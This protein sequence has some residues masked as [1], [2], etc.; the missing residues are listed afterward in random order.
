MGELPLAD[1]TG[2]GVPYW[3]ALS[4]PPLAGPAGEAE[5]ELEELPDSAGL[6]SEP[7]AGDDEPD[8]FEGEEPE[9]SDPD[10]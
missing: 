3:G 10:P 8:P 1:S 7:D 6:E 2:L 5:P 4:A 9:P